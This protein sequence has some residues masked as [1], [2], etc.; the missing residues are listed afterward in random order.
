MT[1]VFQMDLLDALSMRADCLYLS[2]LKYLNEWQWA[3]LARTLE[4]IPADAAGVREWNDALTYL[5]R[6]PPQ[7][8]AEAVRERLIQSLSRPR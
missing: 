8:T 7:E 1:V 3:R 4:E 2:D 5:S 6:Y